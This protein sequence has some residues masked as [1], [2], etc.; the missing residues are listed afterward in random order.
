MDPLDKE[1][2]STLARNGRIT[3][4]ELAQKTGLSSPGVSDR[5]KKL[6]QQQMIKGFTVRTDPSRTGYPLLCF[7]EISLNTPSDRKI[8]LEIVRNLPEI[9]E[10]HHATGD[11][12]YLLKVRCKDTA[13]LER[14]ITV[15]IKEK[16]E[17]I[18]TRTTIILSTEKENFSPW[19][20]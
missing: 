7:I 6:E 19:E 20:D 1:I 13:H 3:L 15:E 10:C 17:R 18:K 14:I 5:I 2:L 11:F 8:F 9:M 16:L 12:D 4:A